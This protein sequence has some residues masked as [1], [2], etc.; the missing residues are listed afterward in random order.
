MKATPKPF[1]VKERSRHQKGEALALGGEED[2]QCVFCISL[3]K[4]LRMTILYIGLIKD[5][6]WLRLFQMKG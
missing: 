5:D 6:E 3:F 1:A 4:K 2:E